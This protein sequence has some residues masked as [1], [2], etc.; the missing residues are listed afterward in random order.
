[1]KSQTFLCSGMK[2]GIPWWILGG[3]FVGLTFWA[4]T[5]LRKKNMGKRPHFGQPLSGKFFQPFDTHHSHVAQHFALW[6]GGKMVKFLSWWKLSFCC[7]LFRV[8]WSCF[9][10]GINYTNSA[11][12]YHILWECLRK[13]CPS[14]Q[15]SANWCDC[16]TEKKNKRSVNLFT[17]HPTKTVKSSH[18]TFL[19]YQDSWNLLESHFVTPKFSH[20]FSMAPTSHPCAKTSLAFWPSVLTR[21]PTRNQPLPGAPEPCLLNALNVTKFDV[22]NLGGSSSLGSLTF[23]GFCFWVSPKE[24]TWKHTKKSQQKSVVEAGLE[25]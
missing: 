21:N 20:N 3:H 23:F 19:S 1:M 14:N 18:F 16:P 5:A 6:I 12:T 25:S 2:W 22:S 15:S 9:C 10:F 7:W 4:I 17:T 24:T 11:E 8:S 13:S